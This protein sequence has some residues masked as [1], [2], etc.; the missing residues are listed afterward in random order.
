MLVGEFLEDERSLLRLDLTEAEVCALVAQHS[1]ATGQGF[2]PEAVAALCR[3]T[4]GHAHLINALADLCVS[5]LATDRTQPV[6]ADHIAEAVT[7]LLQARTVHL[8]GLIWRLRAPRFAPLVEAL[9]VGEAGVPFDDQDVDLRVTLDLGLLRV[10]PNGLQLCNPIYAEALGQHLSLNVEA[11]LGP[12]WWPWRS[13]EGRLDMPALLA[14][15]RAWWRENADMVAGQ[16]PNYPEAVPHLALCAFL[17][18]VINGGGR[19]HREFAAGRG[20]MDLLIEYGPDR[21]AIEIKRV[22]TRDSLETV[23]ERGVIQ[24]GRYL[25]T[26]GLDHGWLVVF[27]VRPDRSWE[28]R[29]W[30]REAE[31]EGKRI[32]VIGG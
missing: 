3:L 30:E 29:L 9:V 13:P 22:R 12:P 5:A 15:F 11:S 8:D 26:V 16:I 20:A 23:I 14:A 28:E 25:D 21:F 10:G 18:R 2:T 24:L 4:E 31:F 32:R 6:R 27:D 19:V 7:R 1:A 17:Q